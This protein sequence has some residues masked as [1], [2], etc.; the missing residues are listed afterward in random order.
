MTPPSQSHLS[1]SVRDL[2]GAEI[3][4][5]DQDERIQRGMTQV[6]SA[7]K[8]HV[9]CT[10]KPADG[11]EL[12][13]RNFYS[14]VV[15]DLDTPERGA[16]LDTVRQVRALSPTS[17][18]VVLTARSSFEETI[19]AIRAGAIDA[20]LKSPESVQY[21]RDRIREAAGHSAGKRE[22]HSLLTEVRE[23]HETFLKRFMDAERRV[24]DLEDR[25]QGRDP[26]REAM[27]QDLRVLVAVQDPQ[28]Y[29]ALTSAE[30]ARF[31]FEAAM[32][33]GEALDRC[34]SSRFDIVMVSD[35]L[36]DL[37]ESM[38]FRSLR[39]Q[40]PELVML[41]ISP[42][43]IGGRVD[44]VESER[45]EPL[46]ENFKAADQLVERLDELAQTFVAKARERR[47]IQA[48]RE[49][50]YDFLRRYVELKMKIDRAISG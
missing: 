19:E 17:M 47:Y 42:P 43:G 7:A 35:D 38:V 48:F 11:F 15:V 22:V 37:P 16:G 21:L 24:L 6:L 25:V 33:G 32:S 9:T 31:S 3:L 40:S 36:P 50:N 28:V 12:L 5:I 39:T 13:R 10:S 49:K 29:E 4:V 45:R 34:G 20:I 1:S 27:P 46:I 30:R 41:A 8:L 2:V 23:A 18:V 14:V 26:D 44:L